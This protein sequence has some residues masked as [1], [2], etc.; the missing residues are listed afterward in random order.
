MLLILY[1]KFTRFTVNNSE[2]NYFL[3]DLM[4]VFL[5]V[6]VLGNVLHVTV[7]HSKVNCLKRV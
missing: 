3:K 7:L 6:C 2:P 1:M 4:F 5:F